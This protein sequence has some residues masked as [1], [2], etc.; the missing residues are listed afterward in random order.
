MEVSKTP[1]LSIMSIHKGTIFPTKF[2]QLSRNLG[3]FHH[4]RHNSY[5]AFKCYYNRAVLMSVP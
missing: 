2:P 1:A 4:G 3:D 5:R